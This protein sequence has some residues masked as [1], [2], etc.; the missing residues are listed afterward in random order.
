VVTALQSPAYIARRES[1]AKEH[2]LRLASIASRPRLSD[3]DVLDA[4][5]IGS[6]LKTCLP[7]S[8][9][10]MIEAVMASQLLFDQLQPCRPGSWINCGATGFGWSNGAALG[11]KMALAN[12]KQGG[13]VPIPNLVCQVIG[14]GS[15]MCAALS[16]AMWIAS[17]YRIPILTMVLNNGGWKAPRNS[18][19]LVYPTSFSASAADDEIN[20]SF[21]PS[22]N[23]AG[24]AEAAVG[25]QGVCGSSSTSPQVWMKGIRARTAG[26]LKEALKIATSRVGKDGTSMLVEALM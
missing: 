22:P 25:S 7:K 4:N 14:D 18:A 15:F 6:L 3:D 9:T 16:S 5:N 26:E 8:T 11:V 12:L 24:L 23:Y 13:D 19:R 17:K 20:T 2:Q 10:F 1:R 21:Q